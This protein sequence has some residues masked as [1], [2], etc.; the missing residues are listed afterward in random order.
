MIIRIIYTIHRRALEIKVIAV[1]CNAL[2]QTTIFGKHV[3]EVEVEL[4]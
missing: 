2:Y 1:I 3:N 4:I